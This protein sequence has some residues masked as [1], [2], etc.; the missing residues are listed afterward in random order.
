MYLWWGGGG[1]RVEVPPSLRNVYGIDKRREGEKRGNN[2]GGKRE[3]MFR[4]GKLSE[5]NS[6]GRI[7]W[8]LCDEYIKILIC[9]FFPSLP[10]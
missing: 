10:T 7:F 1:K 4:I 3:S 9:S 8:K 2:A 6:K 5:M